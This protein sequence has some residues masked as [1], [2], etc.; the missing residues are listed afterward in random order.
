[1]DSDS[2]P[3][4]CMVSRVKARAY[5]PCLHR[6][7]TQAWGM[8]SMSGMPMN[9]SPRRALSGY[10]YPVPSITATNDTVDPLHVSD[11]G[12]QNIKHEYISKI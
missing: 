2:H 11:L 4:V 1:M 10:R 6:R 3:D 12:K 9:D 7:A 8:S 5:V